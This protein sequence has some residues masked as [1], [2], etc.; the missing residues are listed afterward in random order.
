[1]KASRN[2]ECPP[3]FLSQLDGRV[4]DEGSPLSDAFLNLARLDVPTFNRRLVAVEKLSGPRRY[5]ARSRLEQDMVRDAPWIA[6]GTETSHDF[7]SARTGC[8][9]YQP[10]YGIDLGALCIHGQAR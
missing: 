4:L 10:V 6:I 3:N 5:I 8:Q 7:F 1:V 9:V 2:E